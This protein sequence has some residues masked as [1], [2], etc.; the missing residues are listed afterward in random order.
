MRLTAP[1]VSGMEL[2]GHEKRR[3]T[4]S[5]LDHRLE[6]EDRQTGVLLDRDREEPREG[7]VGLQEE[8]PVQIDYLHPRRSDG[9]ETLRDTPVVLPCHHESQTRARAYQVDKVV[10]LPL[11]VSSSSAFVFRPPSGLARYPESQRC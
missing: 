5:L 2:R 10:E 6:L 1:E 4:L 7:Y 3:C 9:R 8:R 11:L